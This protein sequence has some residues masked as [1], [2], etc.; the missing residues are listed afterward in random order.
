MAWFEPHT[1]STLRTRTELLLVQ[2]GFD[3]DD[4]EFEAYTAVVLLYERQFWLSIT[5]AIHENILL[6]MIVA[7]FLGIVRGKEN[8][9]R[10]FAC[11]T[12]N[13]R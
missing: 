6:S 9:I 3:T 8:S 13:H 12:Q 7:S 5:A 1:F 2:V 4:T 10:W 11:T